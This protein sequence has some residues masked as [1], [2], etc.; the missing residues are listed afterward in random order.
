MKPHC[1]WLLRALV[2]S[3]VVAVP[4]LGAAPS[5]VPLLVVVNKAND[6]DD[7][8]SATLRRMFLAK[9]DRWPDGTKVVPL[10]I[11]AGAIERE[12]F[13]AAVLNMDPDATSRFWID[14]RIRGRIAEPKAAASVLLLQRVIARTAGAIGYVRENQLT[15]AVKAIRV[16]G[17]SANQPGYPLQVKAAP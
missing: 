11:K 16:D 1:I 9:L 5:T 7:I 12:T 14:Q 8:S 10:N 3:T 15:P 2:L 4:V 6:I 13:D 17:L